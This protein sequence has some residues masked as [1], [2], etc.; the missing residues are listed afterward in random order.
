M[1]KEIGKNTYLTVLLIVL[2]LVIIYYYY[3]KGT[4]TTNAIKLKVSTRFDGET[5]Q[6]D[7]EP[8]PL[9]KDETGETQVSRIIYQSGY[10]SYIN[11]FKWKGKDVTLAVRA[12][13]NIGKLDETN[14]S[15]E[16]SLIASALDT[17]AKPLYDYNPLSFAKIAPCV[18]D[19]NLYR[20]NQCLNVDSNVFKEFYMQNSNIYS[21]MLF[22][23]FNE[24]VSKQ[25]QG[26]EGIMQIIQTPT[27][28]EDITSIYLKFASGNFFS[29]T[30]KY[31]LKYG[32]YDSVNKNFVTLT[33]QPLSFEIKE[34]QSEVLIDI[35][36]VK[37]YDPET[38]K[39]EIFFIEFRKEI[40]NVSDDLYIYI[41]EILFNFKEDFNKSKEELV[42]RENVN[43]ASIMNYYGN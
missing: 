31:L 29:A 1:F 11:N 20:K 28:V 5:V 39:N 35:P 41:S 15:K 17:Q 2:I 23:L 27:T 36:A 43:V 38:D 32:K 14:K 12:N 37:V 16:K 7:P 30:G 6:V 8:Q 9:R 10:G 19:A 34:G 21:R 25:E 18:Q 40:N 42:K 4:K 26:S 3:N 33:S 24:V 13:V 22:G